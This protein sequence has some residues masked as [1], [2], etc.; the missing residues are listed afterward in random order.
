MVEEPEEPVSCPVANRFPIRAESTITSRGLREG[1]AG[2]RATADTQR[3]G[4]WLCRG[5]ACLPPVTF[6]AALQRALNE[7]RRPRQGA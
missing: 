5:Q 7:R 6:P 1:E 2:R 4:A 3:A